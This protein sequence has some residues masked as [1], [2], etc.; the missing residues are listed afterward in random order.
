MSMLMLSMLQHK[1]I[2][3]GELLDYFLMKKFLF[4]TYMFKYLACKV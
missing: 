2:I 4:Y 1:R 3:F